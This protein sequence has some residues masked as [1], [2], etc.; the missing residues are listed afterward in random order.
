MLGVLRAQLQELQ[1]RPLGGMISNLADD[2]TVAKQKVRSH[3]MNTLVLPVGAV[4]AEAEG[5]MRSWELNLT[6]LPHENLY[7]LQDGVTTELRAREGHA[8]QNIYGA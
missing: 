6:T 2:T 3:T 5:D 8:V 4:L 1:V 7:Q